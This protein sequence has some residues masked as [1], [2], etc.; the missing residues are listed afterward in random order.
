MYIPKNRSNYMTEKKIKAAIGKCTIM[1]GV[2]DT[3]S[4]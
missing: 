1:V 2:F 3:H 4:Q